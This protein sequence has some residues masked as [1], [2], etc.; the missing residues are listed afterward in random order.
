[1]RTL[2]YFEGLSLRQIYNELG[3]YIDQAGAILVVKKDGAKY[4]IEILSAE[5]EG[6][7]DINDATNCPGG[8]RC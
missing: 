5:G 6:S 2:C 7:G 4:Y 3:E 8:P 1:M